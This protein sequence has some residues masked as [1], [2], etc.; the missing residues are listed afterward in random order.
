MINHKKDKTNYTKFEY[1]LLKKNAFNPVTK[2]L[3]K[4]VQN[5]TILDLG[6]GPGTWEVALQDLNPHLIYWH[7]KSSEFEEV[8]KENTAKYKNVRFNNADIEDFSLYENN[9]FDLIIC[10]LALYHA[11]NEKK[12]LS[13]VARTL[14]PGGYLY[15]ESPNFWRII[16]TVKPWDYRFLPM[17]I[18]PFLYLLF[19][20]KIISTLFHFEFTFKKMAKSENLKIVSWKML[21][22]RT[23]QALLQKK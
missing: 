12:V 5:P 1:K 2:E 13:E 8:A 9:F 6:A 11:K 15:I 21:S 3:K 20:K 17:L 4:I 10:R 7:D 19:N 18:A 23:F 16:Q 14:K 22:Q